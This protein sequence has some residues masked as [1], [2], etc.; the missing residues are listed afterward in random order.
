M[1]LHRDAFTH[2]R[3]YTQTLFH[4]NTFTQRQFYTL[5]RTTKLAQGTSQYY[6]RTTKLAQSTSQYKLAPNY[7]PV[8]LRTT[9]LA[10]STSEFKFRTTKLAQST[11]R[12]TSYYKP[13]TKYV[14]N[15]NFTSVL[16]DR[17]SFRAKGLLFRGASLALPRALEKRRGQEGKKV[18]ERRCEKM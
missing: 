13:C 15:R 2:K 9:K 7:V 11:S 8:L 10:Q 16:D 14:K 1:L 6:F 18:R 3:F 4:R 17:T 12:T 5:L